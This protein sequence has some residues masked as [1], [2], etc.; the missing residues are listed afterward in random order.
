MFSGCPAAVRGSELCHGCLP[1]SDSELS[2]LWLVTARL[3]V[4]LPQGSHS[5]SLCRIRRCACIFLGHESPTLTQSEPMI[6][7]MIAPSRPLTRHRAESIHFSY[8]QVGHWKGQ[9]KLQ[10]DGGSRLGRRPVFLGQTSTGRRRLRR[11]LPVRLSRSSKWPLTS[12]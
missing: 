10:V 6:I 5:P 8:P 2:V 1:V 9:V 4:C 3:R 12:N 11:R 7:I